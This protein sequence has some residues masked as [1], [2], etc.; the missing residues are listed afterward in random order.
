MVIGLNPS[1]ANETVNDPTLRRVIALGKR[2]GM[3][4][5][6]M[7][8]LFSFRS[9][10]PDAL[11]DIPEEEHRLAV[12]NEW[13]LDVAKWAKVRGCETEEG[14]ESPVGEAEYEGDYIPPEGQPF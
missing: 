10:L 5:V 3:F 8:N 7:T 13:L 1:S 14:G 12:N 2:L 4:G 9:T 6:V 11:Y